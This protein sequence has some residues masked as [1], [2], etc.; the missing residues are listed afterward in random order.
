MRKYLVAAFAA[1]FMAQNAFATFDLQITEIWPGN[2]PG[3]NLT[4]DWFEVT[5]VGDMDWTSADGDLYFDDDS[6][7]PSVADLMSGITT[8]AA[9]ESVI[10]VDG[11]A[12]TGAANVAQWEVL[13]WGPDLAS[14]PQVG[15][16]EGSGLSGGG[17]GVTLFLDTD[18]NGPSG[19][20]IIDFETYPNAD[21]PNGGQ[22]WD[23]AQGAFSA[24]LANAVTTTALND[25]QLPAVGTP[26]FLGVPEP[27]TI[28]LTAIGLMGLLGVR[29]K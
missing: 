26:G 28:A 6:S 29:R 11:S 27:G 2:D 13:V 7:D 25:A 18:S 19:T 8:I 4:D 12:T 10:F 9:G 15:T 14:L 3:S 23:V 5:N 22:S 20:E 16:Y 21:A 24:T 1:C 17:D